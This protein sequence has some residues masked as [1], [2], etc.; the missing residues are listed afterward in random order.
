M[1]ALTLLAAVLL[2]PAPALAHVGDG[3]HHGLMAGFLHPFS[4]VDHLL[5]MVMVGLWAGLLGG[6]ARLALPGAFLGA[7]ALGGVLGMAGL[8]LPGVEA[9]ILASVV[10]LGALAALTVRL[11]LGAGMA[12]VA[13]F[14]LLHGHAHG[15][16]MLAGS[17]VTYA[18]GFLVGTA[19]LHGAGLALALP[20]VPWARRA[21][22]AAGG[23][24]TL[25]GLA[26]ALLG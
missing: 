5:A 18:F 12:L 21:A 2:L 15:T 3:L 25:A 11:P 19:V 24:A 17:A 4:G 22:Q 16:E 13:V 6:T 10:V 26:L 8:A 9:G 1:N 7:M 20:V 14:G 23:A